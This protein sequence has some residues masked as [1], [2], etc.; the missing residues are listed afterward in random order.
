MMDII[1]P[2]GFARRQASSGVLAVESRRQRHRR[3]PILEVLEQR[4]LLSTV[5]NF[6]GGSGQTTF[7]F[8]QVA[9]P[10]PPSIVTGGPTGNFLLL[11]TVPTSPVAGN[12]N[13]ISFVTS[14]PGTF[15][16]VTADWDFRVTPDLGG[17][18]GTGFSFALLNT[19]NYGTTGPASSAVPQ[20]GIYNGSLAFGFDTANDN[21]FLSLNAAIVTAQSL[22]GQINLASNQFIH[23]HAVVDFINSTVSLVLT[24]SLVGSPVTVFSTTTVSGLS[25]YQARVSYEAKNATSSVAAD[26]ALDNINVQFN[27][28][29]FPGTIAFSTTN[30]TV[31]ENQGFAAIDVIRT[32]GTAGSFTVNFVS[33]DGTGRNGVNYTSES[34]QI[35]FG[36][37][38]T[39]QTVLIP[40]IDDHLADGN[41]TVNLYLGSTLSQPGNVFTPQPLGTPIAATLTILNTNA[42]A[43]T[44]SPSVQLIYAPHTRRVTAFRLTFTQ[45]MDAG[46]ATNLGNYEVILPPAHKHGPKRTV[47]LSQ[48]ILDPSGTMVTLYRANL[49]QHLTNLFQILVR[50]MP[51]T[52]LLSS[53]GTF[54]AG[55]NGVSG[56]DALLKVS[57]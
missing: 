53:S 1:R 50:G 28:A 56:T 2:F 6:E 22:N 45:A 8:Q 47:A 46:R 38:V 9:G 33:A 4:E 48:A 5:Q 10:P 15:D 40:I 29:R 52:G 17:G 27:G 24:P 11:A 57:I 43:P 14:D 21:V 44:V 49:G 55:T 23:A 34:G 7:A 32:G 12:D 39:D 20:Q 3:A 19:N 16:Q 26:F 41:K 18:N 25:P 36:E 35:V 37:G 54:L 42:P 51:P 13:S 31:A 30:Y